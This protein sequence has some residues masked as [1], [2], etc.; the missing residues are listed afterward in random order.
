MPSHKR[1]SQVRFIVSV[2]KIGQ[3]C[4]NLHLNVHVQILVVSLQLLSIGYRGLLSLE[5]R[6]KLETVI[7]LQQFLG[8]LI[9]INR[10]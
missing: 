1:F 6:D 9:S 10:S 8:L 4:L 2:V 3:I 5:L 7:F